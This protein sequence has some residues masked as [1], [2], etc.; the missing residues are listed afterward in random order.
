M[1]KRKLVSL[2]LV[3][4]ATVALARP[5]YAVDVPV[6]LHF[7]YAWRSTTSPQPPVVEGAACVVMVPLLAD[8]VAILQAAATQTQP[9]TGDT[10]ITSFTTSSFP[11]G[12]FLDCVSEVC[13]AQFP[14]GVAL[15]FWAIHIFGVSSP[16][17]LDMIQAVPG[18]AL[19]FVYEPYP[20]NPVFPC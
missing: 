17:G 5:A 19:Q 6:E 15:W 3:A 8:G 11:E 18:L 2:A 12:T 14:T 4:A 10:C 7:N 9:H 20:C 13:A 16:V 1:T